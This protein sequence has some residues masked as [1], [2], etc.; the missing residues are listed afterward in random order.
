MDAVETAMGAISLDEGEAERLRHMVE[1]AWEVVDV[2]R[3]GAW[4]E[5]SVHPAMYSC[6]VYIAHHHSLGMA[7]PQATSSS[8]ESSYSAC[9]PLLTT[10]ALPIAMRVVLLQG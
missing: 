2:H 5:S 9:C 3:S 10:P 8:C 7:Q 1:R 6:I 4:P